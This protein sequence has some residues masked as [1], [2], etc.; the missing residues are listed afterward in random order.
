MH[1]PVVYTA[2]TFASKNGPNCK[3][4]PG[5][6]KIP[7]SGFAEPTSQTKNPSV[8]AESLYKF[9]NI[10]G[11]GKNPPDNAVIED[12]IGLKEAS[13]TMR[14]DVAMIIPYGKSPKIFSKNRRGNQKTA[15]R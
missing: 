4:C 13:F 15:V 7:P 3:L 6:T 10:V 2:G 9:T 11:S 5:A 8:D 12:A 14:I 1:D